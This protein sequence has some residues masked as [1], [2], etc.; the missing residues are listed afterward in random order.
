MSWGRVSTSLGPGLSNYHEAAHTTRREILVFTLMVSFQGV[1]MVTDVICI[2]RRTKG[3][4][5]HSRGSQQ[6]DAATKPL[7]E[8]LKRQGGLNKPFLLT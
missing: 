4:L 7:V 8:I 3:P 6:S 1:P 5:A 2:H